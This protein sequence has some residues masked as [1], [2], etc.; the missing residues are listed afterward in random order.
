MIRGGQRSVTLY[1]SHMLRSQYIFWYMPREL[2]LN[3]TT[4]IRHPVWLS[5]IF[6]FFLLLLLLHL[7]RTRIRSCTYYEVRCNMKEN[8]FNLWY[9][10]N[11]HSPFFDSV[12]EIKCFSKWQ[13][14]FYVRDQ[15]NVINR[16]L[17]KVPK[18]EES[19]RFR[20]F[21]SAMKYFSKEGA[22]GVDR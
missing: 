7:I 6:F 3:K 12:Y 5:F 2:T 14:I 8:F 11:D 17:P 10:K 21:R 22:T 19:L 4:T 15:S 18:R 20:N 1:P 16:T 9:W 13:L